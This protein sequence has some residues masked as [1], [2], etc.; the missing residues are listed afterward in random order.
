MIKKVV[1]IFTYICTQFLKEDASDEGNSD[2]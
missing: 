1:F 2:G